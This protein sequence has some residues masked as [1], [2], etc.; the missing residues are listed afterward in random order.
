[1][2]PPAISY[3][4]FFSVKPSPFLRSP[5]RALPSAIAMTAGR[6]P[7]S[8]AHDT[9]VLRFPPLCPPLSTAV[10]GPSTTNSAWELV[11]IVDRGSPVARLSKFLGCELKEELQRAFV[12]CGSTSTV[13]KISCSNFSSLTH[14]RLPPL[15]Q[16]LSTDVSGP[17]TANSAW[18]LVAIA[19][20]GSPVARLSE[21]F[22]GTTTT[23]DMHRDS[24]Q[25]PPTSDE[26]RE[27]E[28]AFIN[29]GVNSYVEVIDDENEDVGGEPNNRQRRVAE[30]SNSRRCKDPKLSRIEKYKACMDKW[31]NNME[32]LSG[33]SISR[34]LSPRIE[35]DAIT[36]EIIGDMP[37]YRIT[38]QR[39]IPVACCAVHNFIRRHHAM[40]NL[41]MEYSS[42][43][44]LM[45]GV[46]GDFNDQESIPIDSSQTSQMGNVRDE[47]A[48]NMY[49]AAFEASIF[50]K[51]M[52]LRDQEILLVLRLAT[53]RRR[54]QSREARAQGGGGVGGIV[55]SDAAP[56]DAGG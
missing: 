12:C 34:G 4:F 56:C 15:C 18:E 30:S 45:S 31:S 13:V 51:K 3:F 14:H 42:N 16:P 53:Q 9:A 1:M 27:L 33:E 40:D 41:F 22:D 44:M 2:T 11:A 38:I 52:N 49:N 5:S 25:L 24:T 7:P 8:W 46:E 39:L 50:R 47:I 48:S 32:Q 29:R 37:N 10:S 23:G 17:S 36:C 26:E 54:R 55:R 28:E 21:V 20:R 6:F 19:D 43:D 35:V